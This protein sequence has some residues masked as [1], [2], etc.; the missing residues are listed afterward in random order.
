LVSETDID[1]WRLPPA[2][3][4]QVV[5]AQPAGLRSQ[6]AEIADMILDRHDLVPAR[7]FV[8]VQTGFS[9]QRN[10]LFSP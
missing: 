7:T 5:E 8:S 1:S 2:C 3:I 4:K 10:F 9:S 6:P